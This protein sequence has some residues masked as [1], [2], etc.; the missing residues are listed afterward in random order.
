MAQKEGKGQ[1]V[2]KR[3]ERS[4]K[5]EIKACEKNRCMW[6]TNTNRRYLVYMFESVCCVCAKQPNSN[7]GI[8]RVYGNERANWKTA[9]TSE[10]D[11]DHA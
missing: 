4:E 9:K 7:T 5:K 11:Q 1:N 8:I 6:I 10:N 2:G 3:T